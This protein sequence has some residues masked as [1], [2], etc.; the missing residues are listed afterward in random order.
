M[1]HSP[2]PEQKTE[3]ETE[4]DGRLYQDTEIY[5]VYNHN[6][7]CMVSYFQS[8][9]HPIALINKSFFVEVMQHISLTG[10]FH[11]QVGHSGF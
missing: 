2:K 4:Q 10:W 1:D 3:N 11:L 8:I 7:F 5:S 6:V 9:K